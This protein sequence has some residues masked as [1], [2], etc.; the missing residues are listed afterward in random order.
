[1]RDEARGRESF[2][3][4]FAWSRAGSELVSHIMWVERFW[5]FWGSGGF[6]S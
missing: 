2:H 6:W 1:M 5:K 4:G 3:K